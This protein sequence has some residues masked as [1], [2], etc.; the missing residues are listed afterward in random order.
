MYPAP[1]I[2]GAVVLAGAP[3]TTAGVST[4]EVTALLVPAALVAFIAT[5]MK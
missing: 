4:V 3:A 2:A 5:A 1:D